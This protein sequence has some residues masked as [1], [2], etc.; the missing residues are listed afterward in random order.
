MNFIYIPFPLFWICKWDLFDERNGYQTQNSH[1][2]GI[3]CCRKRFEANV[4]HAAAESVQGAFP[5]AITQALQNFSVQDAFLQALQSPAVR[6]AIGQAAAE[7]AAVQ[8]Q[9]NAAAEGAVVQDAVGQNQA[10]QG[11]VGQAVQDAIGLAFQNAN[12]DAHGALV[13][14]LQ[15]AEVKDAV[16]QAFWDAII[17]VR[18]SSKKF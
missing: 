15:G 12:V 4:A 13:Q 14:A 10:V 16:S 5:G 1:I 11:A 17:S 3:C 2:S 9:Q 8:A 18:T 6:D 7:G